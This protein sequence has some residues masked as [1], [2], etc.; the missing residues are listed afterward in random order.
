MSEDSDSAWIPGPGGF[1]VRGWLAQLPRYG[2][3]VRM[4][5]QFPEAFRFEI[6]DG[7]LLLPEE[8]WETPGGAPSADPDA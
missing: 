5:H 8:I 1:D 7:E 6:I 4:I 3:T 2:W